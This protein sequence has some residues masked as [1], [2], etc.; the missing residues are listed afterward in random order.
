MTRFT[1]RATAGAVAL[2]VLTLLPAASEA[3]R[4]CRPAVEGKATGL[5]VLGRGERRAGL[6]AKADWEQRVQALYGSRFARLNDARGVVWNCKGGTI[7]PAKC[8]VRARPC[9]SGRS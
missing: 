2:S 3:A 4:F 1:I 5:G 7:A 9:M 8:S 6:K